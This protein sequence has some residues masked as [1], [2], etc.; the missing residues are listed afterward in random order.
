M[1]IRQSESHPKQ[2][3]P[4]LPQKKIPPAAA[5]CTCTGNTSP[6]AAVCTGFVTKLLNFESFFQTLLT[7]SAVGI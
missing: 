2:T 7:E 1:I 6:A 5:F 4:P 3:K